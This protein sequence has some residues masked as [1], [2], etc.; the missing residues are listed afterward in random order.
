MMAIFKALLVTVWF[1]LMWGV[2]YLLFYLVGVE[3]TVEGG[4]TD[5]DFITLY[6]LTVFSASLYTTNLKDD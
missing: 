2:C 1:A 4:M 3:I 5:V 6:L